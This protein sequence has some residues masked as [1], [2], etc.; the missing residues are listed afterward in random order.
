MISCK[1]TFSMCLEMTSDDAGGVM[2]YGVNKC[3]NDLIASGSLKVT[4]NQICKCICTCVLLYLVPL[5][6][7]WARSNRTCSRIEMCDVR[8]WEEL[9]GKMMRTKLI[10]IKEMG[11]IRGCIMEKMIRWTNAILW[12]VSLSILRQNTIEQSIFFMR[13]SHDYHSHDYRILT[14]SLNNSFR[15]SDAHRKIVNDFL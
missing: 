4:K 7:Q 10:R 2:I 8:T 5:Q 11:W 9:K 13:Y 12:T 6:E 3:T 1:M 15:W 14:R